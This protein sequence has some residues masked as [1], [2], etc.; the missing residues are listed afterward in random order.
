[1]EDNILIDVRKIVCEGV[2]CFHLAHASVSF[3]RSTAKLI[4]TYE[5]FRRIP[6]ETA[7]KCHCRKCYKYIGVSKLSEISFLFCMPVVARNYSTTFIE[8]NMLLKLTAS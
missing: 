5:R 8:L 6:V 7:R 2:G 3:P 1:M 4:Y